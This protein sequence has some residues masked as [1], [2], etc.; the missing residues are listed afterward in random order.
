[1]DDDKGFGGRKVTKSSIAFIRLP[2]RQASNILLVG[3]QRGMGNLHMALAMAS[4]GA[5]NIL[6]TGDQQEQTSHSCTVRVC[7]EH[8]AFY[9]LDVTEK[10]APRNGRCRCKHRAYSILPTRDQRERNSSKWYLHGYAYSG[11]HMGHDWNMSILTGG[12]R[13]HASRI[14]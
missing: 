11:L 7:M 9:T 14:Q 13:S 6:L 4:A 12:M 2:L 8:T 1:M 10:E 5:Y 3:H